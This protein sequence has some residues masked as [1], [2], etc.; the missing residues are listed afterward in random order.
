MRPCFCCSAV[1]TELLFKCG[2]KHNFQMF[3]GELDTGDVHS[4]G[5][6]ASQLRS[7][8]AEFLDQYVAKLAV[9]ADAMPVT[10]WENC[11][12]YAHIIFQYQLRIT[13]SVL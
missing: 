5:K 3:A 6:Q 7:R 2:V 11:C 13:S 12:A 9:M 1:V 4:V 8:C 10:C